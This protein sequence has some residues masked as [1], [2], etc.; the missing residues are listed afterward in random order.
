MLDASEGCQQ[1]DRQEGR[2]EEGILINFF[3]LS[4]R[5]FWLSPRQVMVVPVS[6]KFDEYASSVSDSYHL[7]IYKIILVY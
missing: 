3:L 1:V 6:S 2:M 4:F 7:H 5:P